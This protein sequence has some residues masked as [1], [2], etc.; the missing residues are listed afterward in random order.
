MKSNKKALIREDHKVV[1]SYFLGKGIV[2]LWKRF[3]KNFT[4][5]YFQGSN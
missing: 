3:V 1:T 2:L 5:I 4:E